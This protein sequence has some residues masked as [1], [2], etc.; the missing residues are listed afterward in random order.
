MKKIFLLLSVILVITSFTIN[1]ETETTGTHYAFIT[2]IEHDKAYDEDGKNGYVNI[3]TNIVSVDCNLGTNAIEG[4]YIKHYAA[5]KK[6]QDRDRAFIGSS[7]ITSARIY[8]SYDEALASR[9]DAQ[10]DKPTKEETIEFIKTYFT[11][12]KIAGWHN[13][14]YNKWTDTRIPKPGNSIIIITV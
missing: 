12:L 9:R 3:T 7:G 8:N 6:T 2:D 10:D 1:N 4:Q 14:E 5:E 11:D 13:G